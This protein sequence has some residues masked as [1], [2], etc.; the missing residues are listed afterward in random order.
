MGKHRRTRG[1]GIGATAPVAPPATGSAAPP[2][3]T[4]R[5]PTCILLPDANI[6]LDHPQL[7]RW[8][9]DGVDLTVVILERIAQELHGLGQRPDAT[10]AAA[11]RA[12]LELATWRA[13]GP[14]APC[15]SGS[16]RVR[17]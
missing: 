2:A 15:P 5:R 16:P 12:S 14:H 9:A 6:L 4:V 8:R 10:G 7:T 11:R 13:R 3:A 17:I 1:Q